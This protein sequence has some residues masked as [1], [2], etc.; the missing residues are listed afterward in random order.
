MKQTG[1]QRRSRAAI[2]AGPKFTWFAD[3]MR[4]WLLCENI[5]LV[6]VAFFC[7]SG[8]RGSAIGYVIDSFLFTGLRGLNI[9]SRRLFGLSQVWSGL[10][11]HSCV[12]CTDRCAIFPLELSRPALFH[13]KRYI[14]QNRLAFHFKHHSIAGF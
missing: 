11:R 9:Q 4:I 6:V 14:L 5:V 8:L 13:L 7:L 3:Q 1:E 2:P 10:I 12:S